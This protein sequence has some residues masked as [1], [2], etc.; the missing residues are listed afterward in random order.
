MGVF[1]LQ[2]TYALRWDDGDL[3]GFEVDI[4]ST[5]VAVM[6]QIRQSANDPERVA[7]HLAEHV[8]RWNYADDAGEVLPIV[9][10]SFLSLEE[11]VLAAIVRQWYRAA[12]GVSAPLDEGSTG[13][14]PADLGSIPLDQ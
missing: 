14:A 9:A 11:S 2:R 3:A 12:T 6:L 7:K 5:S 4:R 8:I 1:Q 13:G 10:D